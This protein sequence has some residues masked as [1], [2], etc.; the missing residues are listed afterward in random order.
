MSSS[1]KKTQKKLNATNKIE[2]HYHI[3]TQVFPYH[4]KFTEYR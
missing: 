3:E 1:T 4:K 2:N